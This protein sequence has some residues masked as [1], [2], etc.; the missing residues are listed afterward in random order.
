MTI[1]QFERRDARS[2]FKKLNLFVQEEIPKI[3]EEINRLYE[4]NRKKDMEINT[5]RERENEL[6]EEIR[7][8]ISDT[9]DILCDTDIEFE[10][11]FLCFCIFMIGFIFGLYVLPSLNQLEERY[12][13]TEQYR[14]ECE[15]RMIVNMKFK[16]DRVR[17][18]EGVEKARGKIAAD[19]LRKSVLEIWNKK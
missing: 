12:T 2:S 14:H 1:E 6:E 10:T 8:Y 18:L 13:Y 16:S 4:S 19:R 3:E 11:I 9:K 15:V 17:Y 7:E 5:L